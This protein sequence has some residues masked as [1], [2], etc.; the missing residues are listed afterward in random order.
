[1]A[2][3]GDPVLRY[4]GCPTFSNHTVPIEIPLAKVREDVLSGKL[5]CSMTAGSDIVINAAKPQGHQE[6]SMRDSVVIRIVYL[7]PARSTV[8]R[9]RNFGEALW[10]RWRD[11]PRAEVDLAAVDLAVTEMMVTVR[12]ALVGRYRAQIDEV[13]VAQR[14]A[15]EAIVTVREKP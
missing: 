3:D 13:L 8:H 9:I 10:A 2:S 6:L 12:A 5:R 14:M 11:D 1:M 15:G 7:D 4:M